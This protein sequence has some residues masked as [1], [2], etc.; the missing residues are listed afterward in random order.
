METLII[1]DNEGKIFQSITGTFNVPNG[2]QYMIIEVPI[3][4]RVSSIDVSGE[5]HS[6][7]YEN[8]IP[9]IITELSDRLNYQ[10]EITEELESA[11]YDIAAAIDQ[12][13]NGG[14]E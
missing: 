4:K 5:E 7:V 1:Y 13:L 14:D 9:N 12:L 10:V 8:L 3:G 2:L 6:P 11:L